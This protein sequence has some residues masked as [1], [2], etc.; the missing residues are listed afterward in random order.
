MAPFQVDPF[1][2]DAIVDVGNALP[3]LIVAI[4]IIVAGVLATIYLTDS[5]ERAKIL[6]LLKEQRR[7]IR[8]KSAKDDRKDF[9]KD[10]KDQQKVL[11]K[12]MKQQQSKYMARNI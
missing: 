11:K 9:L 6:K 4:V 3:F 7:S 10:F 2:P 12:L 1:T 8:P 5:D